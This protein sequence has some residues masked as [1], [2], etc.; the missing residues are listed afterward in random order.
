MWKNPQGAYSVGIVLFFFKPLLI[1]TANPVKDRMLTQLKC[2]NGENIK[3]I[4]KNVCSSSKLSLD[5]LIIKTS[6]DLH[7][8]RLIAI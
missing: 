4:V 6:S 8:Y 2:I 5:Y 7:F 3:G 1:D